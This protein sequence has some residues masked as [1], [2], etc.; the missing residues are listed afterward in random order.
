MYDQPHLSRRRFLAYTIGAAAGLAGLWRWRHPPARATAREL[1][2]LTWN[3]FVPASDDELKRQAARFGRQEGVTVHIDFMAASQLPIKLAAE[4]QTQVG[5]DPVLCRDLEAALYQQATLTV[6]DLCEELGKQYGGWWDFAR[7]ADVIE[8]A[9]KAVPWYYVS[10]CNTYREDYVA[11][12]GEP[13]PDTYDDLLR[14]GRKLK[15][16]GHPIGFAISQCS[17][18]NATIYPILWC[19]GAS[20]VAEDGQ[21]II[22]NSPE[23]SEAVEYIKT[24]YHDCM[25]PEVL[26]WD[27][28]SNNRFILLNSMASSPWMCCASA[29]RQSSRALP[30]TWRACG[31]PSMRR[32]RT[33]KSIR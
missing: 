33:E 10:A 11:H 13:P 26:S 25:D 6:T 15:K 27:D 21:T 16:P 24:V 29:K 30:A 23:T 20:I 2:L 28:S 12:L 32:M 31:R 9:W 7:Q 18:A 14:A 22:L 4:I 5:H 17:D 8:G 1:S 19:Y 3:H